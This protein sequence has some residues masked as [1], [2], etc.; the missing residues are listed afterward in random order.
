[1]DAIKTLMLKKKYNILLIF[2]LMALFSKAQEQYPN[3]YFI[4][5]VD[6]PISL[7]GT[8]AELRA[9]HFHSGIDIRTQGVEGKPVF[10]CADGYVSRIKISPFGFGKALYITHPKGYTTVYAHLSGFNKAIDAWVRSEQ[11]RL[12]Q[13]DVDLFPGKNQLIVSQGE[14]VAYSGNS[15]SSQGPHLHF[16]IRNA[17]N[18]MPINPQLFSIPIK[19]FIRPGI[20]SL[21]VYPEGQG[22]LINGKPGPS[23]FE[24]AGWGP[25]HRL[26]TT[27]TVQIA[28]N[29]SF[30]IQVYDLL[31]GSNN[32]NG[33]SKY[34]IYI[35]SVLCFECQANTFSFSESRYINSLIDYQQYYKNGQRYMKSRIAPNNKLSMYSFPGNRGIFTA[36]PNVVQKI[37]ITATDGA[38]NESVLRFTVKGSKVAKLEENPKTDQLIFSYLTPN[39][40]SNKYISISIPGNC[41]YDSINFTYSM[42]K[43]LA[44]TCSPVHQIHTPEIPLQEYFDV[45]VKVDSTFKNLGSKLLLA[46]IRPGKSASSAGGKYENG[47]VKARIRDFGQYAVMADTTDPVIKAVN[48]SNGKSIASQATIRMRISDD[49]SGINTYRA[50]LNGKWILMEYDAKNQRLE[51]QRD[52]RLI[53][54]K[55]DFLLIVEDGCGNSA[56][57]SA[58]LIN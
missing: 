5:P 2:L 38:G 43:R 9:N 26:K 45:S 54:G 41:L 37:K 21:R 35:D 7:S 27:D 8:F 10:A 56:S 1:M 20:T 47:F 25:V 14:I 50:T 51:Y 46:A 32:K 13:F 18:E 48:I 4:S 31:N 24:T 44:T 3:D 11:Y 6:F 17:K 58:V 29:F 34:S 53:T 30:G 49:F 28:G 36:A 16:E 57:Y 42:S 52:D 55:N 40:Y 23:T 12:E 15:G 33:I 39:N 22:S 19:D